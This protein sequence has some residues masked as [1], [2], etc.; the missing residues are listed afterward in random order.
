MKR[1]MIVTVDTEIEWAA[2]ETTAEFGGYTLI[3]RPPRGDAAADVRLEYDH[4]QSEH[5]A[6]ETICRFL[7][8]LSW[9]QHRSCRG[10]LRISSTAPMRGGKGIYGPPLRK[11]Y[12]IPTAVAQQPDPQAR[13][14]LAL[15]R[16]A[17]SVRGTPYEFLGYFKVIN[18]RYCSGPDQVAW[19]NRVIPL[20]D[21]KDAKRRV[22]ELTVAESD[23]GRYL[24]ASGRCAVAHAFND[25][26]VDPDDP[27][28]IFRLSA[29]MPV[30][31]ALAEYLIEH[32]YGINWES[33]KK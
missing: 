9:W 7:S 23:I 21:D 26:V 20:L 13:I 19:I 8:A 16:E 30:A 6:L 28:D 12:R 32:E 1:W 3:L 14:A 18:T 11:D 2:E 5:Y 31:K 29:D 4:P 17:G 27:E 22:S 33:S 24:Y 25:P 10:S 15:Y